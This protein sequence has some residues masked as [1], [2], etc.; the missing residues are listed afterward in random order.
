[1]Y[2]DADG[3]EETTLSLGADY[4]LAKNTKTFVFYTDNADSKADGT[5]TEQ[6]TFGIGL[7]HKF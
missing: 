2:D 1:M 4:K 6:S 3:D 5:E 7:E